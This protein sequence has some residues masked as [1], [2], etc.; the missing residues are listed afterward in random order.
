MIPEAIVALIVL[1]I[2]GALIAIETP[3]VQD[4]LSTHK[5]HGIHSFDR[6]FY[7]RLYWQ[8]RPGF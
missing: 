4:L 7:Y 2:I 5:T 1:M 6:T 3:N 8:V